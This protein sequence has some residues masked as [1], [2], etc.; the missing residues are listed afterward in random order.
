MML[1]ESKH[2]DDGDVSRSDFTETL[3]E[4]T[5]RNLNHKSEE[6]HM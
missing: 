4:E 1:D 3:P 2:T 5:I 6:M